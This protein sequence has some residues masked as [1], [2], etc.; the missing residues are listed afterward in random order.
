[1]VLAVP[2][3]EHAGDAGLE[4]ER[5]ALERP[6]QRRATQVDSR[7]DE[8]L[9]VQL[10]EPFDLGARRGLEQAMLGE[11]VDEGGHWAGVVRAGVGEGKGP[12]MEEIMKGY[13][14]LVDS[15]RREIYKLEG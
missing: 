8:A 15:G 13:H 14:D 3:G 2:R 11:A 7:D 12:Q 9:L 5:V 1:M 4:H 10:D 6:R